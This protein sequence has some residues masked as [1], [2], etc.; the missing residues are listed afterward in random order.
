[1]EDT[2]DAAVMTWHSKHNNESKNVT[3]Q[4]DACG[5]RQYDKPGFA[6]AY[7]RATAGAAGSILKSS[8]RSQQVT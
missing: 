1:M 3:S 2:S 5:T 4:P 8:G 6:V 7:E